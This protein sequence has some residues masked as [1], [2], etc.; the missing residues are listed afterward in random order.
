MRSACASMMLLAALPIL[1]AA[2]HL[3][4][5][6]TR[7][8]AARTPLCTRMLARPRQKASDLKRI[9]EAA[10]VSTAGIV[11]K[12]ELV[13]LVSELNLET[14]E[15][16]A[17]ATADGSIMSVPLVYM[18]DGA[19]AEVDQ[20]MRLLID[21][22]SA[23]SI[24]SS[25]AGARLGFAPGEAGKTLRSQRD[26]ALEL[27]NF[28]VASPQQMLPDGVDGILGIDCLRAFAAAELDWA[29]AQLKLHREPWESP[30]GRLGSSG[31][32]ELG[33]GACVDMPLTIRRVAGGELPFV[34]T[35]FGSK[36]DESGRCQ[37]EGLVDTGS[38]V[39]MVTPELAV[40]ARMVESAVRDDDV[41]T[42]GVD[43][44]PTRMRASR[45]EVVALGDPNGQRVAHLDARVYAGTCPMMA[46]V[47]WEGTPAAL[48]GL[49]VLRGGVQAGMPKAA[50]A[51]GPAAGRLVLDVSRG[52][53]LIYE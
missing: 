19:Y 51:G 13:R 36:T 52:R 11:E 30:Q 40:L 16:P 25:A 22:G 38:P 3:Q 17:A 46:A 32:V 53:L 10:G 4:P 49:D 45:C 26:S 15:A 37:V 12:E 21:T 43:G 33:A 39:T 1:T 5:L 23:I 31:A 6:F 2:A 48:L 29:A 47:G 35:A 7:T 44:Q 14:G 28:R 41:L 24:V 42:T 27:P 9:L 50:P 20:G 18:M 34:T 8:P